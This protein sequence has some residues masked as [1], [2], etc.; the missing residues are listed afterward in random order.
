MNSKKELK[1]FAQLTATKSNGD[2][3]IQSSSSLMA[4][5][6]MSWAEAFTHLVKTEKV[7][8]QSGYEVEL[9]LEQE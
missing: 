2:F 9:V 7:L 1:M 6:N 3:V 5:Q 4:H 8:K